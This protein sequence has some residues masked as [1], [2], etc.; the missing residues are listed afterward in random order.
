MP[1]PL[2]LTLTANTV[3]FMDYKL[4]DKALVFAANAHSG[5]YRKGTDVPYIT[6][7]VAVAMILLTQGCSTEVVVA[8][9]LHDVIEDTPV[10]LPELTAT[11][12]ER[13][14]ELVASASEPD[15]SA[16]WE[17]RK[18]HTIRYLK[19]APLETKL[20][21]CAD[22]LHNVQS[23][24]KGY[25]QLGETLWTRFKRGKAK[26]A[27]YYHSLKQNLP[28]G[29]DTTKYP[30]FNDFIVSVEAIFEQD[31]IET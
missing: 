21:A 17:I 30:V 13:V 19:E 5:Q 6:H 4:L 23:M 14:A 3:K 27:W 8:G 26:Q 7:P 22:K 15:R 1:N 11:F 9:L 31:V 18:E 2:S 12:G 20:I 24:A 28:Y 10:T 29:V 25:A 16:S